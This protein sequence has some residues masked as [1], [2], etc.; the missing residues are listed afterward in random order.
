MAT[1]EECGVVTD[2]KSV[3]SQQINFT[4]SSIQFGHKVPEVLQ[5]VIQNQL[6]ITTLDGMGNYLSIPESMG[7]SKTKNLR[8]SKL[9]DK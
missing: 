6:G 8:L 7:G 5:V 3:S 9:N 4:K 2:C 1:M